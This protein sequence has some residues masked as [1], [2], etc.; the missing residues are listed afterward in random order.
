MRQLA[1]SLEAIAAARSAS[2]RF[3]KYS[4][5]LMVSLRIVPVDSN[6]KGRR[7][8]RFNEGQSLVDFYLEAFPI[9]AACSPILAWCFGTSD[10]ITGLPPVTAIVAP[11][12]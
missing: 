9:S 1:R 3:L 10:Q 2:A 11:E 12:T 5:S 6:H 8:A 7:S 4:R